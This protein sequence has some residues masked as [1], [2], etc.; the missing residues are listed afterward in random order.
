[1]RKLELENYRLLLSSQNWMLKFQE[2][3]LR[4]QNDDRTRTSPL[5]IVFGVD[6]ADEFGVS[7]LA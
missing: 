4:E 1:M 2:A 5:I 3:D 6:F 7:C